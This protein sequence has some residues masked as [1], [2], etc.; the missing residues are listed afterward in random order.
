[1][2]YFAN[3][4]RTAVKQTLARK[5]EI[6]KAPVWNYLFAYEYPV[7]GGVT[8]FHCSEI[9]FAFYNVAEPHSRV[10]TGGTPTAFG[11]QDKVSQAWNNVARTGNPTQPGLEWKQD[12]KLVSLTPPQQRRG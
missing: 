6:S 3:A 1:M 12:D 7:N 2:P 9:V 10:A 4:N 5:L 8:A 11:L